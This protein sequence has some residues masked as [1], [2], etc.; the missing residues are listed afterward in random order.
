MSS[1]K[2]SLETI[3][4]D[5]FF[6]KEFDQYQ[7]Q[8]FIPGRITQIQRKDCIALTELG[9]IKVRISGRFRFANSGKETFPVVGDWVAIKDSNDHMGIIQ[10]VLP[11]KS[12]FSRKTAGKAIEEQIIAAN[13]DIVWIVSAMDNDFN[14]Q[15]IERYITLV[16]ESGAK[17]VIIL[18]KSD[19]CKDI[20]KKIGEIKKI[21]QSVPIH[22]LS[23]ELNQGL[24]MLN[25]YLIKGKTIALLGS[26]GVGKSTI[27]N[28]LL[29]IDRQKVGSVR[30]DG[31]GKHITTY[32]EMIMLPA[33]GM[34]MDNPG[35]R[36]IQLWYK[37]ESNAFE[38]IEELSHGCKF[39]NCCHET[40]PGCVVKE[41]LAK[42]SLDQRRYE[43]YLKLRKEVKSRPI[44]YK[45]VSSR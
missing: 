2:I 13:V 32:R 27:I 41:A 33:G 29:G 35:M 1:S 39:K 44:K 43:H 37:G 10:A 38:D 21:S 17:P 7:I 20:D 31:Q 42:G 11:R 45:N 4:W 5:L 36:E 25:Q 18:N 3:G 9:E 15:R 12:K 24:D 14:I 22:V 19:L 16:S 26:S 23:A 6:K 8:G 28:K 34:I 30:S 40:E